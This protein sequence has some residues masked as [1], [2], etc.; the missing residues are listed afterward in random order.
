[1]SHNDDDM[2]PALVENVPIVASSLPRFAERLARRA[3]RG[4]D[5]AVDVA[6]GDAARLHLASLLEYKWSILA[7]LVL[8]G[9]ASAA[10]VWASSSPTYT[11]T[12]VIDV[13]PVIRQLVQSHT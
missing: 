11:A 13:P 12:A 1:M 10:L 5:H 6:E 3:Q 9:C 4:D 2:Q 8:S 7:V